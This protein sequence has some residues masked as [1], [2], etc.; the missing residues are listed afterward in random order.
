MLSWALRPSIVGE[1]D[2][3]DWFCGDWASAVTMRG[4]GYDGVLAVKPGV[5][6]P[7]TV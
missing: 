7:R 3:K 5:M 4:K 6:P 2:G 1:M